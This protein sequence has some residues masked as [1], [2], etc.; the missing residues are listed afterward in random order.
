MKL[1]RRE[2][3]GALASGATALGQGPGFPPPPPPKPRKT[4]MLCLFSQNLSRLHYSELGGVMKAMG[5]EGCDLT[6]RQ[7]GHVLSERAPADMV[8]A[9]EGV[10]DEGVDVAMITTGFFSAAE[11][12]ARNV[13]AIAGGMR[14]PFFTAGPWPYGG[15]TD[16]AAKVADVKREV[17]GLMLLG[18]TYG[19]AMGVQNA[20]GENVGGAVW[21]AAAMIGDLDAKWV[22]YYYDV[23][24]AV[25][26]GGVGGWSVSLRLALPRLKMVAL[27]DFTW[28]KEGGRWRPKPCPMGEGMVD[29]GRVFAMLAQARFTGPLSLRLPYDASGD[30]AAIGKDLDFVRKVIASAYGNVT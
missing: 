7:G 12:W 30:P 3:A 11:P 21:D 25:M 28:A 2:L 23:A 10:R 9:I 19:I 8:R 26:E 5:I 1:S 13:M 24:A 20:A 27:S 17:A 15:A 6:I 4:P 16:I 18:R 29:W 22:G 14:V